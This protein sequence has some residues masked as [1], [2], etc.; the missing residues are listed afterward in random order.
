MGQVGAIRLTTSRC[1][2]ISIALL[3]ISSALIP[4]TLTGG[5]PSI[6]RVGEVNVATWDLSTAENL[7]LKNVTLA[8]G[9]AYLSTTGG[10]FDL[11]G[12]AD[13]LAGTPTNLTTSGGS[14]QIGTVTDWWD[15]N[16]TYRRPVHIFNRDGTDLSQN[17][18][19][20]LTVDTA[21]LIK[22]GKLKADL[23]D[24]RLVNQSGGMYAE[25]DRAVLD[26]NN[27]SSTVLFKGNASIVSG[28]WSNSTYYIYYG[29][30]SASPPPQNLSKVYLYQDDFSTDTR[31]RY[32]VQNCML[33]Q[34]GATAPVTYDA[35]NGRLRIVAA[36][37]NPGATLIAPVQAKNAR[38][39]ASMRVYGYYRQGQRDTNFEMVARYTNMQNYY[40]EGYS[41][42]W[43]NPEI[44]K[45]VAGTRT[46]P[47]A[48]AP[49]A[50]PNQNQDYK[51]WMS[52]M[53]GTI[54]G[55]LNATEHFN[56]A[57]AS[58]TGSG[59][60][61]FGISS[62]DGYIDNLTVRL[63]IERWPS[64][65]LG[66]EGGPL[67]SPG[68]LVSKPLDAGTAA[69]WGPINWSSV[70]P[71]GSNVTLSTRT[72][73]DA[74]K[75]TTWSAG[76]S[77]KTGTAVPSIPDRYLQFRAVLSVNGSKTSPSLSWVG[78]NLTRY[79][80]KGTVETKDISFG[81]VIKWTNLTVKEDT[82]PPGSSITWEASD[83]TGISWK[84]VP[85]DGNLSS[86]KT[87]GKV[88]LRAT[89]TT[90]NT[91]LSPSLDDFTVSLKV[92]QPPRL[93]VSLPSLAF[94]ED[95]R[96]LNAFN[97][98]GHF[99]DD[100]PMTFTGH[101]SVTNL[102]VTVHGNGSVDLATTVANWTGTVSVVFR[103]TD[104]Y[105][106]WLENRTEVTV[107][108]VNDPPVILSKPP[109]KVL[110]GKAYTYS[111][112]AHDGDGDLLTYALEKAPTGMTIGS[113]GKVSWTPDMSGLGP[114][115]VNLS[116]SDKRVKVYQAFTVLVERESGNQPP[117]IDIIPQGTAIAGSPFDYQVK[118]TDPDNDTL[119][120]SL[121]QAPSGM[122]IDPKTGVITWTPGQGQVGNYTVV[123]NV[124]DVF[125]HTNHSFML[126]VNPK[127]PNFPP[128]LSGP[129]S[130][131]LMD[132]EVK[133]DLRP[134]VTDQDDAASNLTWSITGF[135]SDLF[136][137]RIEGTTLILKAVN[138]AS[139]KGNLT[140][141]V[142][143]P[144]G[145][146]D[147]RNIDV[148]V[149]KA[150]SFWQGQAFMIIMLALLVTI[151]ACIGAGAWAVTRKKPEP[152]P[153]KRP[154]D[155][156][157]VGPK[158]N[159]PPTPEQAKPVEAE[160]PGPSPK[161]VDESTDIVKA[162][163]YMTKML[164]DQIIDAMS[165]EEKDD[166]GPL[167]KK[168]LKCEPIIKKAELDR[169]GQ[170]LLEA[171][172]TATLDSVALAYGGLL[173]A[174]I[175]ASIGGKDGKGL[176]AGRVE[177]IDAV[178]KALGEDEGPVA[179]ALRK[180]LLQ[181]TFVDR[182]TSGVP[183]LDELLGGGIPRGEAMLFQVPAGGVK[184][185]LIQQV[186]REAILAQQGAVLS[187]SN[188][189]PA[190][191]LDEC[192]GKGLAAKAWAEKGELRLV[193]WHSYKT[194]RVRD[195]EEDGIVYRSSKGLTNLAIAITD[196]STGLKDDLVKRAVFDIITPA[197]TIFGLDPTFKL[198][199][200]L[201]AK[202]KELGFTSIFMIEKETHEPEDIATVGQIFDPVV[203]IERKKDGRAVTMDVAVLSMSV[204]GYCS[205]VRKI[206]VTKEGLVVRDG[207]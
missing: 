44:Y 91:T 12:P 143:D 176:K 118:A 20:N 1:I 17:F 31:A 141:V 173:D 179:K 185:I 8:G 162:T 78:V 128:V 172:G 33:D 139:G 117:I 207:R 90:G 67:M 95:T 59:N 54:R 156:V 82:S 201:V 38:V 49:G 110:V 101:P 81:P 46:G 170:L 168:F 97:L 171:D 178:D 71:S 133:I 169:T 43:S 123:V 5:V 30:P 74:S 32:S 3:F 136:T 181:G 56:V 132:K 145:G 199:Q 102:Q 124:S 182:L 76:L 51:V 41:L 98:T 35:V 191:F 126:R 77:V 11:K 55:G 87:S 86:L 186:L 137:A 180:R 140:L 163:I 114:N 177:A 157:P 36:A 50:N 23:S 187:L 85:G 26:P 127:V 53:N 21:S 22:D 144:K 37:A 7:T 134:Y 79:S 165:L 161:T 34:V 61:G 121:E 150:S 105:G 166:L 88:R 204:P 195:V 193:D 47:L 183:G 158:A 111:V 52:V 108:P 13:L 80:P 58:L 40:V 149:V 188:I 27:S 151:A 68:L 75:W 131:R 113:V 175:R 70:T 42:S 84:A 14:L 125:S 107:T 164:N 202:L 112:I 146:T 100:G 57:D 96:S 192:E 200:S 9:K 2:G 62:G 147:R 72:S 205:D 83:D 45:W 89:M 66:P 25:L 4:I 189:A 135:S 154:K 148:E 159:G 196:A 174:V 29:Y 198:L 115:L 10:R 6:N 190:K 103:A 19:Y 155:E 129:P 15:A 153:V 99:Q 109:T 92:D 138:G 16:Y 28:A 104:A 94:P 167:L 64:V 194:T 18:T 69:T 93:K 130:Q 106:L 142:S 60:L 184:D 73:P 197:M 116:V 119:T 160:V 65:T 206:E 39:E 48:S 152:K 203:D 122:A 24:L 63:E 120:Y